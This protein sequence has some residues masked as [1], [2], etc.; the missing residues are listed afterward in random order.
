MAVFKNGG[1]LQKLG[2]GSGGFGSETQLFIH[3]QGY[4]TCCQK[5]GNESSINSCDTPDQRCGWQ[6]NHSTYL[7]EGFDGLFGKIQT[8][9]HTNYLRRYWNCAL[10]I[11]HNALHVIDGVWSAIIGF[12][13]GSNRVGKSLILTQRFCHCHMFIWFLVQKST[14]FHKCLFICYV[15]MLRELEVRGH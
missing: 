2:F 11:A 3:P 12:V 10:G 1:G 5:G 9:R 6:R 13:A 14:S 15:S 7:S 4:R 8:H